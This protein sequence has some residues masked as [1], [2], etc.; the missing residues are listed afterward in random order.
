MKA[1]VL[2]YMCYEGPR[3]VLYDWVMVYMF[4]HPLSP[5][6][7]FQCCPLRFYVLLYAQLLS[8]MFSYF[9]YVKETVYISLCVCDQ[10]IGEYHF[11]SLD[12]RCSQL[13]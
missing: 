7:Y 9:L 11:N 12:T 10:Q 2:F 3:I 5:S 1:H 13:S 6:Y 4:C 8:L